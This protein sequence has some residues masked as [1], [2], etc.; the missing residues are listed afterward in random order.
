MWSERRIQLALIGL[1]GALAVVL[2][3]FK[4]NDVIL[5]NS[6]ASIPPGFYVR[7]NA[8]LERGAF[9]TVR[10]GD[11][12]ADYSRLRE[13]TDDG[14]RF[15]KRVV[16]VDGDTVCAEGGRVSVDDERTVVRQM[17]DSAGREL[18]TW[19]GCRV[20]RGEVFLLGDT[21]DSFDGRYWGPTPTA[22]VEGVWRPI[23]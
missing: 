21:P 14:D 5:Y 2:L 7:T 17:R 20:L 12:A 3:G 22:R 18:P 1:A 8:P 10:A 19:S 11:M 6:S 16:A 13:F 23:G 4:A 15:I 9:V